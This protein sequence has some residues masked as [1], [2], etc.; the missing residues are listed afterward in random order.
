MMDSNRVTKKIL[1]IRMILF[2]VDGV[3]TDGS[4]ILGSGGHEQKQFHVQDGLGVTLARMGGLK[5]GLI[6]GRNSDVVAQRAAEL[7]VDLVYQGSFHKLADYEEALES[8]GFS[9]EQV[10][11][12]GD[13]VLDLVLLERAGLSVAPANARAEVRDTVDIVTTASGGHGAVRELVDLIL[14]TQGKWDQ[15][16]AQCREK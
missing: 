4:I 1:Y 14:K 3:L 8:F 10:C 15:V 11:Y 16:M 5:T 9:D 13:D 6:T 7:K 2:D 12:M